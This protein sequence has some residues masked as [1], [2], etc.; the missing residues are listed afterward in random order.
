[1]RRAAYFWRPRPLIEVPI[2][3]VNCYRYRD[4][5]LWVNSNGNLWC[6]RPG[7]GS[8]G[9]IGND[10]GCG[11]Q[12]GSCDTIKSGAYYELWTYRMFIR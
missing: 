2:D 12:C 10:G 7:P 4:V 5:E 6:S 11:D 1:M 9:W 3:L 8:Y